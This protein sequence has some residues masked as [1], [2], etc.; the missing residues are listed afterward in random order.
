MDPSFRWDDVFRTV[1]LKTVIPAQAGIHRYER[2]ASLK[3]NSL[4]AQVSACARIARECLTRLPAP[5]SPTLSRY[6]G[7]LCSH[8][9]L[10][11]HARQI[12]P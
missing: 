10:S 11:R 1:T 8:S 3:A 7:R 6:N 9:H 4:R 12:Q 5:I 2:F